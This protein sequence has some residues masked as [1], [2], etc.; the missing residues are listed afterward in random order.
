VDDIEAII[1]V[2]EAVED[3]TNFESIISNAKPCDGENLREV[4]R[5]MRDRRVDQI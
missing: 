4:M 2:P 1:F 3:I 5:W